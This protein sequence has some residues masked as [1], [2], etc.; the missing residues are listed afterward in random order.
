[1]DVHHQDLLRF[2]R[3]ELQKCHESLP[4][5]MILNKFEG[6]KKMKLLPYSLQKTSSTPTSAA[7]A[8]TQPSPWAS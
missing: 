6:I 3:P 1:V 8:T 2:S 7:N 5:S 4:E